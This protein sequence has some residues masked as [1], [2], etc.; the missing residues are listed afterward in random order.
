MSKIEELLRYVQKS[1][2]E[3]TEEKLLEELES[4]DASVRIL[5][6]TEKS[7]VLNDF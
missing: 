6:L 4:C 7:C 5:F 3:M 2:P 1:N